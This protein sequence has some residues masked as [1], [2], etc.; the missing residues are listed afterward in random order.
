MYDA[1]PLDCGFVSLQPT[2]QMYVQA[3]VI[4][5]WVGRARTTWPRA[6]AVASNQPRTRTRLMP[7][8]AQ[9]HWRRCASG[10]MTRPMLAHAGVFPGL[11]V[12]S[13]RTWARMEVEAARI[14]DQLR[15]ILKWDVAPSTGSQVEGT[16][17]RNTSVAPAQRNFLKNRV[18]AYVRA[19]RV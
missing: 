18:R 6:H 9:P 14:T 16:N 10:R 4:S 8:S 19:T 5:A 13:T 12:S 2:R 11:P 15:N 3:E 7:A 1:S 17:P